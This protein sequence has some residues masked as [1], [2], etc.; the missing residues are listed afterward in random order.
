MPPKIVSFVNLKGGVGKTALSV[1]FAAYCGKNNLKT[2]L[3]D[4]DPQTNATFSCITVA[5]WKDH[6]M[7]NGTIA[8]LMGM[9][10]HN[11]ADG[12]QKDFS[13]VIIGNA[14][15][16]VDLVP[17]HLDLFTI[18]LDLASSTAR[19]LKVKR[20]LTPVLDNYDIVVCDCPPNLTIPTQNAL[21]M[22]THFVVPISP[23]FLSALGV[24]I[25]LNRVKDFCEDLSHTLVHLGIVISRKGRPA[26]HRDQITTDIRASFPTVVLNSEITERVSVSECT[27][28]NKSIFQSSDGA[29]ITEFT[30]FSKELLIKLGVQI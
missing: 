16:G 27:A 25:L 26:Y 29:A 18:D 19:E 30:N 11:S 6:A 20:A 17:S 12:Q 14:L 2:L 5:K 21:A 4:L 9:K 7:K 1:N 22:S 10:K 13:T 8:D 28:A 15:P 23:D 3:V 24:G